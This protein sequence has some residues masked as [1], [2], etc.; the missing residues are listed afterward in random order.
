[1]YEIFGEEAFFSPIYERK[2]TKPQKNIYDPLMQSMAKHLESKDDLLWHAK[3]IKEN[4][5]TR[6]TEV[7]GERIFYGRNTIPSVVKSRIDYFDELFD[8]YLK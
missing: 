1:M 4:K 2:V 6:E 3:D 8:S 7:E 5:Y